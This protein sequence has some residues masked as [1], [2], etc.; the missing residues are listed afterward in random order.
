MISLTTVKQT[1]TQDSGWS[2][3]WTWT[4]AESVVRI[5]KEALCNIPELLRYL[6][7][8]SK[9]T[10][11][12]VIILS[13]SIYPNSTVTI[14]VICTQTDKLW[15]EL[16]ITV[17]FNVIF[18]AFCER[19]EEY[20]LHDRWMS[21]LCFTEFGRNCFKCYMLHFLK[22]CGYCAATFWQV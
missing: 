9:E 17:Q 10:L 22:W 20:T 16:L 21:F 6:R 15:H 18:Q 1:S 7:A 12:F 2:V 4:A 3:Y 19:C 13:S 5:I 11:I 8:V 14:S